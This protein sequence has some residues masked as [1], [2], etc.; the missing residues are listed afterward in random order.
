ML[1]VCLSEIFEFYRFLYLLVVQVVRVI[2]GDRGLWRVKRWVPGPD[3]L[4]SAVVHR[5][6]YGW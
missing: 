6:C 4:C 3:R 2:A 1:L 5:L